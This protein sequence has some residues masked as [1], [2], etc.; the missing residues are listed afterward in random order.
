MATTGPNTSS[1]LTLMSGVTPVSTVGRR[2][3]ASIAA[4]GGDGGAGGDRF[5]DPRRDPVALVRADQ[6]GDVGGLV[7][8]V[9]HDQLVDQLGRAST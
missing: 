5:V 7:E 2:T 4:A 9:A 8:R 1:R 3:P 6:G